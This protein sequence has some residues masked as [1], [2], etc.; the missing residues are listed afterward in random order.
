MIE[1]KLPQSLAVV[2]QEY[3]TIY[4]ISLVIP[5]RNEAGNIEPLLMRIHQAVKGIATE[6]VF[7]DDST[8]NTP[9]VIGKLQEWFPLPIKLIHRPKELRKNGLGGAVVEGFKA[10]QAKW[11]CVMDADLQHPP[12]MIPRL[13]RQAQK[14]GADIVMGS[15]LAAGGDA[16]SLGFT[17]TVI[18]YVFAWTTRLTFPQRLRKVTDPLTGFFMTRRAA[19]NPEDLRPDGFKILLEILVS[20]PQLKVA[21]VPIQF[22][23]RNAGESKASLSETVKFFR[24]LFRLRMA[25]NEN[26]VKFLMVGL[27]GL[28]VN[29][30]V[31][32]AFTELGAMHFILSAILATQASTL[33]NFGLT[34]GWVFG[35]RQTERNLLTRLVSFLVMNNAML[36]LR[37]PIMTLLVSQLGVHYVI[38]NLVSLFAM[39]VLRYLLADK[40]I[41]NKNDNQP[42]SIPTTTEE[43]K[44][45][46]STKIESFDYSY[47]I[48]NILK[49]A[50]MFELPE[51]E[52]FRVPALTADPDIRLRL[53]RRRKK[54]RRRT[55]RTAGTPRRATDN[56]HY[57]ESLG[58]YGFEVSISNK[59]R[60]DIAVS[61]ILRYSRHVLYT[62]VVEPI[63]RWSFVRKGYAL[64]HAACVS[65]DGQAVLVTAQTDTG[66]TS[67]ILRTVDN[68]ACSFLSDDMT[69]VSK[70]G[71]VM[72]YPKPLTISNHT[73][74]AVNANSSLTWWERI[75]LQF[76]S[77]LH[78]KSGRKVGLNL[79]KSKLPAATMNAIVQM[80]VP[81]PKYMVHRL[82]PKA[83]YANYA[84]L[85][86]AV[87]IERGPEFV[88]AL[89]HEQAVET[90]VHNA[91]DA[92]GFPPYPI[93]ADSLSQ[94]NGEDLHPH[95]QAIVN[96][97]LQSIPTIR[98]RDPKFNWWQRL[99]T[100][101]NL[102]IGSRQFAAADD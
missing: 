97:A 84:T 28:V 76:Q 26:F 34:E 52:Y 36:L 60:V 57:V 45:T 33:W 79:S 42:T 102:S 4:D 47:N 14:S 82:I 90:F 35:K 10:A 6:V 61:S 73:L 77:R 88:E 91:E 19:V 58:R 68:Y 38:A 50:S 49:V 18:S 32:W 85:S 98:L 46:M 13:Y 69:I 20:H 80:F 53:E 44:A 30:V 24:G 48:H 25:G 56:I 86:R 17:R 59:N 75:A 7:V 15:R 95:E 41:W 81:P 54:D 74:S 31:L 8:D 12:E 27:S 23:Y 37:G 9:E 39:T 11:M 66:K 5:T 94:W 64:V 62:N 63:L 78:S 101:T 83:T 3:K 92:Y 70:D 21:E 65:F 89:Q 29:S 87:I 71:Q 55:D 43:R 40:W 22:G 16:S 1:N 51:L 2:P 99:P 96:E 72:S 100:V 93:L 67:T